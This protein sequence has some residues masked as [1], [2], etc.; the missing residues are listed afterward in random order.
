MEYIVEKEQ[1][2]K[3]IS[4]EQKLSIAKKIVEDFD[5]FNRGREQQLTAAKNISD[6]IYFK[7]VAQQ[8]EDETKQW[9]STAKMCKIF[10]YSQ[11]L[12]AFIWKN[13]YA[14]TNSMF[15]VSGENLESDNNSNK[16]QCL[17]IV[18]KKWNIQK[19]LIK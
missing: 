10:M 16:N 14:N 2:V 5:T 11:I 18:W 13:T 4:E 19:L 8:E 1:K 6:E 17:L 3:K 9:K 7:S 12:K 15:D